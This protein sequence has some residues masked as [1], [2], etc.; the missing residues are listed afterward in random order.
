MQRLSALILIS[1]FVLLGTIQIGRGNPATARREFAP[2]VEG[3]ILIKLRESTEASGIDD[4][5]G[6]FV[7]RIGGSDFRRLAPETQDDGPVLMK[8]APGVAVEDAVR[9]ASAD[10]D[11]EYAE[12]NYLIFPQLIPND[13]SFNLQWQLLNNGAGIAGAD[14][15]ATAAWDITTGASSLVVAVI[16]T[17][18]FLQHADLSP[19]RWVN[20][21]EI[22]GNGID[23]DGNGFID[24]INGWNFISSKN[25]TFEDP[26]SDSHGTLVSGLV[27]AAG[28]NGIGV[29]GV[30]W[31][32]KLMSVKFIGAR[33]GSTADAISSVQYVI[34]QKR[35]GVN[36][37]V[38]NASW[39][40]PGNSSALKKVIKKAGDEGIVFVCA[41]GNGGS[42]QV[43]DDLESVEDFPSGWS[44]EVP[45]IISV[46]ALDN[47][48][49]IA[50]FSNYGHSLV[51]VGAPGVE[52]YSTYVFDTYNYGSGTSFS[53]PLVSGIAALLVSQE[54]GLSAAQVRDRI[55][56]TADPVAS[57]ASK[58]VSSGRANAYN[59]LT[60]TVP[61][62]GATPVIGSVSTNKKFAIVDGIG[63]ISGSSVIEV[64]GVTLRKFKYDDSFVL[65]DGSAT[66]VRSKL[67]KE[68]VRE[69]FP[70]FQ[71]VTVT[72]FNPTTGER[73]QP[74]FYQRR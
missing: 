10:P 33:S 45:S 6:A 15:D 35:S 55:V 17:G 28:N 1:L 38:I 19:N 22:P 34:D 9:A 70:Q 11:V 57:L 64:N 16:D 42:D 65:A 40:G 72:V 46:A 14:I 13:A 36:V 73:S 48:D 66:R 61:H 50:G 60:N 8:L 3:E 25:E 59:A 20:P 69:T 12:P 63:L 49:R 52:V 7:S 5:I 31:N 37:R 53:T 32:V 4:R 23:D 30:A 51:Q 71:T 21:R 44:A 41:A 26:V 39:G 68:G 18:A 24:D 54:P 67:G 2:Y 62:P 58:T 56:R 43:G 27:G 29:S 74:F 47:R